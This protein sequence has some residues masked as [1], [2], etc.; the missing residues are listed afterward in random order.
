MAYFS[1]CRLVFVRNPL[2]PFTDPIIISGPAMPG[3]YAA[4]A[5]RLSLAAAEGCGRVVQAA[6]SRVP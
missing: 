6:H 1:L 3:A 5:A 4:A 2:L